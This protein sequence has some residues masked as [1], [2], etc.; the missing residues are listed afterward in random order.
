MVKDQEKL[1]GEKK[2]R[3][4]KD[5]YKPAFTTPEASPLQVAG[6]ELEPQSLCMVMCA[7]NQCTTTRTQLILLFCGIW[8]QF[9]CFP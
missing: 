8:G 2:K 6:W 3:R 7:L 9:L 4:S 1:G 5:I